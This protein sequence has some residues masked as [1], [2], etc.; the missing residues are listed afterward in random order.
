MTTTIQSMLFRKSP[1][2]TFDED[3]N[4]VR[5]E[6]QFKPKFSLLD[7]TTYLGLEVE[8]ERIARTSGILPLRDNY[9]LWNNVPDGSLRNDGKEFVTVPL[10]GVDVIFALQTLQEHLLKDKTCIAHEFTDRT[11]VHVHMNVLDLTGEQYLNLVLTYLLVE[12]L[13][14]NYVGGDRSK[15][16]F[17]V[18]IIDSDLG[19]ILSTSLTYL[20]SGS[21]ASAISALKS[22]QKYTGFNLLP[23]FGYGTVEFR[24]LVGT[25]DLSVITNWLNL[26]LSLKTF[27]KSKSHTDLVDIIV[28]INTTSDYMQVTSAIFGNLVG[29]LDTS[30]IQDVMEKTSAFIKDILVRLPNNAK[31]K[32]DFL[33]TVKSNPRNSPLLSKY[34]LKK[35]IRLIDIESKIAD[36]ESNITNTYDYIQVLIKN[37]ESMVKDLPGLKSSASKLRFN[38]KF[39]RI[40]N[41]IYNNIETIKYN[42]WQVSVLLNNP[43]VELSI[44][45]ATR[46]ADI[47][48]TTN[49]LIETLTKG[50]TK[51]TPPVP[52]LEVDF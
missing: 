17:C 19:D 21:A 29:I 7:N 15:N 16:I 5:L 22:W 50:I 8:V 24:H 52:P 44:N 13:L 49:Q 38:D 40:Q 42:K 36:L 20:K 37:L 35:S 14:Y 28:N 1:L 39:S 3:V 30:N 9:H 33:D 47:L 10:K 48:N 32:K 34:I 6:R 46:I 25:S 2:K 26:I 41:E 43:S 12:P 51:K 18:P 27:A 31:S 45:D 11:S 4:R 23:T